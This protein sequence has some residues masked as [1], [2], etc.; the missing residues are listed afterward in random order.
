MNFA[1][2]KKSVTFD[3]HGNPRPETAETSSGYTDETT[4]GNSETE[5]SVLSFGNQ[6]TKASKSFISLKPTSEVNFNVNDL[7]GF[8]TLLRSSSER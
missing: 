3:I 4:T 5:A 7:C 1:V 6:S 8:A 2:D